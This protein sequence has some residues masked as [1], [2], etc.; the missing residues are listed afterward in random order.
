MGCLSTPYIG[1]LW[2]THSHWGVFVTIHVSW[3]V[4][5]KLTWGVLHSPTLKQILHHLIIL[6]T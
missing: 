2:D 3:G 1:C 4:T 5:T 6:I